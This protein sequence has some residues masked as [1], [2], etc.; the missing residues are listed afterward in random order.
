MLERRRAAK[1]YHIVPGDDQ[2]RDVE[3]GENI[4]EQE[5]GVTGAAS[6]TV[7]EELDNWDENAEDW[8]TTEPTDFSNVDE[9]KGKVEVEDDK[10]RHD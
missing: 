4:G 6:R 5:T 2:D 9:G 7:E 10:K 8:D 1:S 3:L